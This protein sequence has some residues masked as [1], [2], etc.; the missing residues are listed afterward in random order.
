MRIQFRFLVVLGF[1]IWQFVSEKVTFCEKWFDTKPWQKKCDIQWIYATSI[2]VSQKRD[3]GDIGCLPLN[4][5]PVYSA[6]GFSLVR[7][8]SVGFIVACSLEQ[9]HI[10]STEKPPLISRCAAYRVFRRYSYWPTLE[11]TL[12]SSHFISLAITVFWRKICFHIHSISFRHHT[13]I[14]KSLKKHSF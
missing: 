14:I 2:L 8:H 7:L 9:M 1:W 10:V 12:V 11:F 4:W 3:N 6:R 13:M 5:R